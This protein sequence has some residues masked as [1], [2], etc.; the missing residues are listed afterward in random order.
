MKYF[1]FFCVVCQYLASNEQTTF[2]NMKRYVVVVSI[3][4]CKKKIEN[5]I[6]D[7]GKK[8]KRKKSSQ[9]TKSMSSGC[10]SGMSICSS[11]VRGGGVRGGGVRGGGVRGGGVRGGGGGGG[12]GGGGGGSG[13]GGGGGGG[14]NNESVF[15]SMSRT[16]RLKI[17]DTSSS[18]SNHKYWTHWGLNPGP[19]ACEADVIPLHHV[20][21]NM[22]GK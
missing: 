17:H 3:F 16:E 18:R 21:H 4:V 15:L 14:D 7:H 20:P 8:K 6:H 10:G 11:G 19:S 9:G 1:V 5:D 12:S 2:I 22:N 13:S